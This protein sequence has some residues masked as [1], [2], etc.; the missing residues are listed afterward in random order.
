MLHEWDFFREGGIYITE[1]TR[2]SSSVLMLEKVGWKDLDWE[3]KWCGKYYKVRPKYKNMKGE[4][5][6]ENRM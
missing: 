1:G 2:P 4:K 5:K 3:V 6:S